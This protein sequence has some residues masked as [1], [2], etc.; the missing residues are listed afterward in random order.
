MKEDQSESSEERGLKDLVKKHS[1]RP[2]EAT[3]KVQKT[4]MIPQAQYSVSEIVN[5][6]THSFS[7]KQMCDEVAE[8]GADLGAQSA[9]QLKMAAMPFDERK[10][11]AATKEDLEQNTADLPVVM[12]RQVLVTEKAQ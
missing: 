10:T 1:E 5:V 9:Q 3:Q 6:A 11:F 12:Q 8:H 4:V 7:L 2:E